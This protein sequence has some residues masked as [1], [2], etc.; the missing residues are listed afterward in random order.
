MR[1]K[2]NLCMCV[3]FISHSELVG[4]LMMVFNERFFTKPESSICDYCAWPFHCIFCVRRN[5]R[6]FSPHLSS[7]RA[8]WSGLC[9]LNV[10]KVWCSGS[11][12]SDPLLDSGPLILSF[13]I[14]SRS[15]GGLG[16]PRGLRKGEGYIACL[17]NWN[18]RLF[19][20]TIFY[21]D[22]CNSTCKPQ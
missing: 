14:K 12:Y 6:V 8:K 16:V 4:I 20:A 3:C 15:C 11:F 17:H 10:Y 19:D 2:S 22:W 1:F 7:H 9:S 18:T 21:S 13:H 5:D